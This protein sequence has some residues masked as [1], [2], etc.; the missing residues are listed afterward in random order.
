MAP[1]EVVTATPYSFFYTL[2][3]AVAAGATFDAGRRRGWN[4]MTW[5]LAVAAWAAGGVIGAMLPHALFGDAI[6]YRTS[7]GA[8]VVASLALAVAARA[9]GRRP[10]EVLDTTALA[11]PIGAAI[12]RIGCFIGEC[13]QGL[14]TSLPI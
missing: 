12:V 14:A 6:A 4:P 13:C 2:A 1:F 8:V 7:I 9:L 11:L 5:G 3:V 10:G